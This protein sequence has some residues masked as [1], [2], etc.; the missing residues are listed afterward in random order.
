MIPLFI[1]SML[2]A[3]IDILKIDWVVVKHKIPIKTKQLELI[4]D[5]LIV[6]ILTGLTANSGYLTVWGQ[7]L[8]LV[9]VLV[10]LTNV[11]IVC[12]ALMTA[13]RKKL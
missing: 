11:G 4:V 7:I 12:A 5:G 6:F 3:T 1:L 13:R 2:S 10:A 8:V 9:M